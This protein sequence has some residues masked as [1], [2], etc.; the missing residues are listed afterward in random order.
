MAKSTR[1]KTAQRSTKSS[2]KKARSSKGSS[3]SPSVLGILLGFLPKKYR[4]PVLA[5]LTLM[6]LVTVVCFAGYFVLTGYD[7]L[8]LFT[9]TSNEVAGSAPKYRSASS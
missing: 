6:A 8:G 1:K 5:I 4:A 9:E 3:S 2:K 7:P